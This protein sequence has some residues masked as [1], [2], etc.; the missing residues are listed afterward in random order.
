MKTARI[1]YNPTSG[2]ETFKNELPDVLIQ[3]ERSGYIASAHATTRAGDATEAAR[4]ACDLGFDLIIAVG[5]DGTV[6]EVLNGI[7]D[8][9]ARPHLGIIPMGTVNDFASAL[10]IPSDIKSAVETIIN[11]RTMFVDIGQMNNKYFMNIAG[12][13]KITEVSYEAPSKL[14]AILGP[15]AY[16]IKGIEILPQITSTNIRIEYDENVFEG[17]V[18]LFLIG[19]TNSI[20]GFDKLVPN[21]KFNDGKFSLLIVEDVSLVELARIMTMAAR[22]EHLNHEKVHYA[23]ARDIRVS[24]YDEVQL[25]LDGEFG[26]LLPARFVNHQQHIA[27]RVPDEFYEE[28]MH[29][30][31]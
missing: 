8:F 22:G 4:A 20:G 23:K 24:S 15:L 19:L 7:A 17:E 27:I 2:R 6:S 5:G 1:I 26:G 10:Y 21:A 12:G 29:D 3:L 18:M 31:M 11:G 28:H 14:K 9:E 13:G 30:G 16:Y 25:N